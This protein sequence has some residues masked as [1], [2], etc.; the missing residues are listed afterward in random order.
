V[1]F[2]ATAIT[3]LLT[4]VSSLGCASSE[5]GL[6]QRVAAPTHERAPLFPQETR[7]APAREATS[8]R[9]EGAAFLS[10][11]G[12]TMGNPEGAPQTPPVDR[13]D[14]IMSTNARCPAEMALVDDRV[15]VDRWEASLVERVPGGAE[16]AWSPFLSIDG[17]ESRVRAV[18]RPGV[19]PQ[20][21]ISGRQAAVAC[22]NSGKRLCSADE[23]EHA[24][25]GP[26]NFQ[27]PYGQERRAGAC[28]DD[29]RPVHPVAEVSQ[30]LG[31]QRDRMWRD[32]MNETL[33][34]QLP[35]TLLPTGSRAECTNAYGVY[36]MVGNLH[37]WIDD[38][39]GTFRGG[40]Y[41]DTTKNGDGCS[42]R[43]MAHDFTYHDYSTGFRC[44]MDPEQV[45]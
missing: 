4:A 12:V 38:P 44:C 33:I 13:T 32:A 7:V 2:A 15:C 26:S 16:K 28:N 21:Y 1:R 14:A 37:E 29:I 45:E 20:G 8:P 11:R 19:I 41:M 27:F 18:S 36:D 43:T 5:L 23:W 39:D 9:T 42:Y 6:G 22:A 35:D 17:R 31:I 30:L 40:Y 25:R 3:L 10:L 34:N 24:C